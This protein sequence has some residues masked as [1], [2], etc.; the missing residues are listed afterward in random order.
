MFAYPRAT[1]AKPAR[2]VWAKV[3]GASKRHTDKSPGSDAKLSSTS[4]HHGRGVDDSDDHDSGDD[5]D[6]IAGLVDV[7]VANDDVFADE[8]AASDTNSSATAGSGN[9]STPASPRRP[10]RHKTQW[11]MLSTSRDK[12]SCTG[13]ADDKLQSKSAYSAT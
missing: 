6:S 2:T 11:N 9:A 10:A 1:T 7:P 5:D 4:Q 3:V 13:A 8:D 12:P